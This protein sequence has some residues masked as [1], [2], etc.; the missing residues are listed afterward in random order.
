MSGGEFSRL[1]RMLVVVGGCGTL[2]ALWQKR[3]S[4]SPL[5]ASPVSET[6]PGL[7]DADLIL[8]AT[9]VSLSETPRGL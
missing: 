4:H 7:G 2:K 5:G 6:L 8:G 9:C 1:A 3:D